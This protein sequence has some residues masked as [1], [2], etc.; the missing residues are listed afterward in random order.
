MLILLQFFLGAS[1]G[2]FLN[3]IVERQLRYES[4][5]MP[6]SHC[7][8]CH[9]QLNPLQLIPIISYLALKGKCYYCNYKIPFCSPVLELLVGIGLAT[10]PL[11]A[12]Q[13]SIILIVLV[14]IYLSLF[15]LKRK[16]IPVGGI[17]FLFGVCLITTHHSLLQLLLAIGLY[18]SCLWLNHHQNFV[19]NGD[20]DI[21]FCLWV[22][23]SMPHLLW[24]CCFACV[25]ALLYLIVAPW[26]T[27]NRIPF[28]PFITIG[29][30]TVIHYADSLL[31]LISSA[32]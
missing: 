5:I 13:P 29:T 18:K 1:L 8:Q 22:G 3:L 16:Q 24:I 23:L 21:F 4:I 26:P 6:R 11:P 20:I 7:D 27:D 28:V 25:S 14:L 9:H 10:T 17:I 30:F 15:D 31:P 19:G 32:Y 2:S 12:V